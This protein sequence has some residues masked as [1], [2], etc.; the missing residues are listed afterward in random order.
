M[1]D[2][3]YNKTYKAYQQAVYRDSRNPTFWCSIGVLYSQIDQFRDA[4]NAYPY[5]MHIN[6]CISE[7][8]FDLGSLYKSC[9]NQVIGTLG[10]YA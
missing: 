7:V 10:A 8:W 9:N 6:P 5:T 4:L 2:Q 3:K 1:A